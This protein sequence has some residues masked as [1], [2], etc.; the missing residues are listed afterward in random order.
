MQ[1]Q[2]C[3]VG[4][5]VVQC[6]LCYATVKSFGGNYG[7][8]SNGYRGSRALVLGHHAKILECFYLNKQWQCCT[9][10][11]SSLCDERQKFA[12]SSSKN[13]ILLILLYTCCCAAHE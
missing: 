12:S 2:N 13:L 6:L 5:Q 9:V 3:W 10:I 8:A 11:C 1:L 4:S 7:L